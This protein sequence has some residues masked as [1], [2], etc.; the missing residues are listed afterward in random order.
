MEPD[1]CRF[2]HSVR[3]FMSEMLR[4]QKVHYILHLVQCMQ[5]FRP[6]SS[7]CTER[8][9]SFNSYV[10]IQ[11]ISRLLAETS[12]LIS[13]RLSTS[14]FNSKNGVCDQFLFVTVNIIELGVESTIEQL[15]H[16]DPP[17]HVN[18]HLSSLLNGKVQ[19]F[20]AVVLE[21][22]HTGDYIKLQPPFCELKY[23]QLLSTIKSE[24]GHTSC[25]VQGRSFDDP[26]LTL[27]AF[28]LS[29][30]MDN[31]VEDANEQLLAHLLYYGFEQSKS[32]VWYSDPQVL[33]AS[34]RSL[35]YSALD[36]LLMDKGNYS[37]KLGNSDE[38][39]LHNLK[40]KFQ[41]LTI[42]SVVAEGSIQ[43]PPVLEQ[44]L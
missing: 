2:V 12:L 41:P 32:A 42:Y 28:A 23:G 35:I 21:L 11:N 19:Q 13:L 26:D 3:D 7:F 18:L 10:R 15:L 37:T 5:D 34:S 36:N 39:Q 4:K 16:M 20:K 22:V 29:V 44:N 8:P 31:A 25:L 24:T 40:D 17:F 38:K 14:T 30:F 27:V 43:R 33:S 1:M 9:E 6:S